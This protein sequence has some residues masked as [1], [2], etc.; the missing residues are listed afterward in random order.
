MAEL[1][2]T[3]VVVGLVST[4]LVSAVAVILRNE[5]STTSRLNES[6]DLQRLTTW[7]PADVASTAISN[8]DRTESTPSRCTGYSGGGSNA[9]SL[10][11]TETFN[12]SSLAFAV[13]YRLET[14]GSTKQLVRVSCS[15][16]PLLGQARVDSIATQLTGVT[17]SQPAPGSVV[18]VLTEATGRTLT[19]AATSENPNR[20]L[21]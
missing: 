3:I 18:V 17:V 16:S 12:G 21:S 6:R 8:V 15:G 1:L 10:G 13:S 4:A 9:M 2:I 19:L 5:G 11:W 7:F 20:V 14:V